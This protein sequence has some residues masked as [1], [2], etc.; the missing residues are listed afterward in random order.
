MTAVK[1]QEFD[2]HILQVE[3]TGKQSIYKFLKVLQG[4]R[5]WEICSPDITASIEYCRERIVEM[6][7]EEYELWFKQQFPKVSR[8]QTA[9]PASKT[10]KKDEATGSAIKGKQPG[11]RPVHSAFARRVQH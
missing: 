4:L 10:D 5:E 6:T 7:V 3:G 1:I 11:G 9:P 2:H 8:P